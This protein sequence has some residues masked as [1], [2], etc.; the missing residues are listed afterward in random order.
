MD[1]VAGG[2]GQAGERV[3]YNRFRDCLPETPRK[4]GE[5]TTS[6]PTSLNGKMRIVVSRRVKWLKLA[7]QE[8][9]FMRPQW[10]NVPTKHLSKRRYLVAALR[11]VVKLES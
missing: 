11:K 4:K 8:V 5:A 3:A 7:E 1:V 6:Q 2:C 9:V 10:I